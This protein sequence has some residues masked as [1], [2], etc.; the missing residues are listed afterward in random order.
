MNTVYKW[1]GMTVNPYLI[2]MFLFAIGNILTFKDIILYTS[3]KI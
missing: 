1:L 2:D 3:T